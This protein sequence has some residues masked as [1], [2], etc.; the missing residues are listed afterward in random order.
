VTLS[1]E[2]RAYDATNN[3]TGAHAMMR[4][5]ADALDEL[6]DAL[7]WCMSQVHPDDGVDRVLVALAKARGDA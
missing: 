3:A 6:V 2:L 7:Q 4:K 5:A 1:E